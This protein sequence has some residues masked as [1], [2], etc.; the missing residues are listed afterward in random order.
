MS[1]FPFWGFFIARCVAAGFAFWATA[2][3]PYAFF[4]LTRWVV[5]ATCC[6]GVCLCLRKPWPS[7]MPAYAVVGLLFNPL[8]L[9]RFSR[10]TWHNLDI[11][12]AM[13]LLA[14]LA[15]S[16]PPNEPSNKSA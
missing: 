13:I 4:V 12:A 10:G 5:F 16:R 14:S 3:H 7:A 11:A 6:W 9:F 8:F 1:R 2:R 15:F